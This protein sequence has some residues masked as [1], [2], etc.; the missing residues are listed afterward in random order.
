MILFDLN[1]L[2]NAAH[3]GRRL[4]FIEHCAKSAPA[5]NLAEALA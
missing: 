3:R 1:C 5:D 2:F 4:D